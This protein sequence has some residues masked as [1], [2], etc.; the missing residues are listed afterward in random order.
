MINNIEERVSYVIN[1]YTNINYK[2]QI[3]G[4]D[5]NGSHNIWNNNG[6]WWMHFFADSTIH[7]LFNKERV[8]VSLKTKNIEEAKQIRNK[9]F[10]QLKNNNHG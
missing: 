4:K 10:E 9:V 6:T 3:K 7:Y 5:I 8:R 2:K 1:N